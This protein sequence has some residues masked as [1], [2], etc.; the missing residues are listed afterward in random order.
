VSKNPGNNIA[1][2]PFLGGNYWASPEGNG[3][4]QTHQDVDY[5]GICETAYD[6]G[7]GNIDYL[8]LAGSF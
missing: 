6:M 5:D 8:P 7:K 3:F 4:S 1:G 2:G